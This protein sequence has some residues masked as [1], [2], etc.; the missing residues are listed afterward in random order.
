MITLDG[1]SRRFGELVAVDGVSLEIAAGEFFSLLGPSGCGK[2]TTLRMIAGFEEPDEG[3]IQLD[4]EDVTTVSP[5]QRNVNMV[6]QDYAL[7]PHMSVADNVGFGLRLKQS[8]ARRSPL[9]P[10]RCWASSV[11]KASPTVVP[12][13]S[14]AASASV[15]PW[16]APSS[17][18]PRRFCWTSRSAPS[19]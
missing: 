14:R 13:S 18:G 2:T 10:T 9:E 4:G 1:V 17:T 5:K 16:L 11:W 15:S 12:A 6:F 7:F 19:T 8:A 3:R